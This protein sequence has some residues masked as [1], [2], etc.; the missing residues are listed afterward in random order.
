MLQANYDMT[1]GFRQTNATGSS[2]IRR[3]CYRH[4]CRQRPVD[5]DCVLQ[6]WRSGAELGWGRLD[7]AHQ[8]LQ[9]Q[10]TDPLYLPD[11]TCE[12]LGRCVGDASVELSQNGGPVVHAGADD[13][14]EAEAL[15]VPG[16]ESAD[17][18]RLRRPQL[19]QAGLALLRLGLGGQRPPLEIP[20]RQVWVAPQDPFFTCVRVTK[21]SAPRLHLNMSDKDFTTPVQKE[22]TALIFKVKPVKPLGISTRFGLQ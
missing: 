11:G 13:E 2:K 17:L 12:L 18:S 16:V 20:P 4:C 3:L 7:G 15:L 8:A 21:T 1:A 9:A 10:L 22:Q 5:T 14:G 6:S 19:R